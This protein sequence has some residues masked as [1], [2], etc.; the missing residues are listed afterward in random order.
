MLIKPEIKT[1]I[2]FNNKEVIVQHG[3]T[4]YKLKPFRSVG[5]MDKFIKDLDNLQNKYYIMLLR[6]AE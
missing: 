5:D 2:A 3:R 4:F 6:E 1:L